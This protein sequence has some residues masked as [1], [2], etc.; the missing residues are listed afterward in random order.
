MGEKATTE[1]KEASLA[2]SHMEKMAKE[3]Q[4]MTA[5]LSLFMARR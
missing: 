5:K 3:N 1:I 4:I 2:I